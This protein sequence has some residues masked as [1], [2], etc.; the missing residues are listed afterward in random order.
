[1][2]TNEFQHVLCQLISNTR[3]KGEVILEDV[4]PK[5]SQSWVAA[6]QLTDPITL[7]VEEKLNV[8]LSY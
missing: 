4:Q 6:P 7:T 5:H 2:V 3:H 8:K 1:M